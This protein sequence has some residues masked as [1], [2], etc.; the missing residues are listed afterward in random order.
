MLVSKLADVKQF[1]LILISNKIYLILFIHDNKA[2][3]AVFTFNFLIWGY[4]YPT[5]TNN[6][7][8]PVQ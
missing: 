2:F 5:P 1:D 6:I 4:F 8:F 3:T 7:G